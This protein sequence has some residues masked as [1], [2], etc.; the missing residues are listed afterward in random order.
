MKCTKKNTNTKT[1]HTQ[2]G[3]EHFNSGWSMVDALGESNFEG[4]NG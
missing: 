3:M 1:G 2:L 4:T